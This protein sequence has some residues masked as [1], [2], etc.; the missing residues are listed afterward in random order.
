MKNGKDGADEERDKRGGGAEGGHCCCCWNHRLEVRSGENKSNLHHCSTELSAAFHLPPSKTP[1]S[2]PPAALSPPTTTTINPSNK[3]YNT[4]PQLSNEKTLS[5]V[6]GTKMC[7]Q[8]PLSLQ[9][10]LFFLPS[11]SSSIELVFS[12]PSPLLFP[13]SH[14]DIYSS[15]STQLSEWPGWSIFS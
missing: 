15:T 1:R 2:A 5:R 10:R 12:S 8:F 14:L 7:N 11:S 3:T 4:V 9:P 6:A 13:P